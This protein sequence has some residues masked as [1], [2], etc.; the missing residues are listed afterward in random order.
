MDYQTLLIATLDQREPFNSSD[1]AMLCGTVEADV[2]NFLMALRDVGGVNLSR[3][4]NWVVSTAGRRARRTH[5]SP[6]YS[7]LRHRLQAIK[8]GFTLGA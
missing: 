5:L 8:R 6:L 1:L 7:K 3:G 4:G 2:S